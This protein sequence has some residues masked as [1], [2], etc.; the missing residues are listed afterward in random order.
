VDKTLEH[1]DRV[2]EEAIRRVNLNVFAPAADAGNTIDITLLALHLM[3]WVGPIT[4]MAMASRPS[5]LEG[6]VTETFMLGVAYAMQT[7][8]T[9]E[10]FFKEPEERE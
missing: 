4:R 2:A 5:D 7:G 3:A 9:P 10:Q 8:L 6:I 1:F